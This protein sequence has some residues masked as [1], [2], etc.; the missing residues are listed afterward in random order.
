MKYVKYS[1]EQLLNIYAIERNQ[2]I[3]HIL[4]CMKVQKST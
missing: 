2:Q 1:A 4:I 3:M